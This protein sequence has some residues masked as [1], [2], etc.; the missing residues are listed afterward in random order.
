MPLP[1]CERVSM[2]GNEKA[3]MVQRIHE[4]AR[5]NLEKKT[6]QYAKYA[7]KNRREM[8]FKVGYKVWIHLRKERFPN[9]RKS[10]LMPRID[11]PF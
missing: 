3:E 4:Q 10:K 6:D 5:H 7:N 2:D 11:A 8:V 1:E 9:E